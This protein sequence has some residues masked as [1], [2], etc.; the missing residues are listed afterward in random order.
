MIPLCFF[1][2]LAIYDL[3]NFLKLEGFDLSEF[4]ILFACGLFGH[5]LFNMAEEKLMQME[6]KT[7]S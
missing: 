5:I 4:L 3:R 6:P 1:Y 2:L 7:S